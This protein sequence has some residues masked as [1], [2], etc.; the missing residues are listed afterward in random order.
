M[1]QSLARKATATASPVKI[2]GVAR[3]RVSRSAN[4]DPAAPLNTSQ[5]TVSGEAPAII[6]SSEENTT[7]A[8]IA[9]A[10]HKTLAAADLAGLG[11]SRMARP[12]VVAV[13]GHQFAELHD[14]ELP[15]Q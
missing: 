14:A 3:V 9:P 12:L 1:F 6:T 7:V 4:C 5:N 10:G 8:S 2:S 13:P 15:P 11:S